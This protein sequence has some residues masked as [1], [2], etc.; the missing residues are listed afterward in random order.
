MFQLP[1]KIPIGTLKIPFKIEKIC[2]CLV[3]LQISI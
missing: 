1:L 3:I 2:K